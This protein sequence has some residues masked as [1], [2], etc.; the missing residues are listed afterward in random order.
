VTLTRYRTALATPG[1]RRV[2]V[3]SLVARAPNGMA[4]LGM[5]LLISRQHGYALA[6]T[7]VGVHVGLS[8]VSAPLLSRLAI[9]RGVRRVLAASAV[10]FAAFLVALAVVP[11]SSYAAQVAA[12]AGAGLSVPPV[13]AVVRGLWSRLSGPEDVQVL[14]GLEAT[15]QEAIYIV[16]PALVALLAAVAGAATALVVTGAIGL[17]G[18][19]ALVA[20]PVFTEYGAGRVRERHRLLRA[21]RLPLYVAL[22]FAMTVMF[23]MCDIGVVAFVSG[24]RANAA[25]GIVLACWSA[26]S[27]LGGLLFAGRGG[28]VDEG[29]VARACL[30]IAAGVAAAAAAP[31]RIGLAVILFLGGMLIAPGLAR[32][33]AGVAAVVPEGSTTEA[34][35]W[36]GVG[37]MA[38]SSLGSSLGGITVDALSA[39]ATFLLAAVVPTVVGGA[40]LARHRTRVGPAEEPLAS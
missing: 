34:F 1:V 16:G 2:V 11:T 7:A 23:N 27:M 13:V 32:L 22:A 14:Y 6:G 30:A 12:C 8:C 36:I 25:A 10:A 9:S 4:S 28:V 38:G 20:S 26:G 18:T 3:T 5:I 37:F 24:R 29:S 19:V 40:L 21:S 17:V 35:A 31:G 15:A 33:Y 39:R